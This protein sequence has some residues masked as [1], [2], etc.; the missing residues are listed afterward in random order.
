MWMHFNDRQIESRPACI[1]KKKYAHGQSKVCSMFDYWM[2]EKRLNTISYE[3]RKRNIFRVKTTTTRAEIDDGNG[4]RY[5]FRFQPVICVPLR[6]QSTTTTN[7]IHRNVSNCPAILPKWPAQNT[8]TVE[9]TPNAISP[10]YNSINAVNLLDFLLQLQMKKICAYRMHFGL[11]TIYAQMGA[12]QCEKLEWWKSRD[13]IKI[14][15]TNQKKNKQQQI[16]TR[17]TQKNCFRTMYI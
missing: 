7:N 8:Y 10:G 16:H 15:T 2:T 5:T 12:F 17:R 14:E 11:C 13:M 9:L 3:F 6:G 1:R 4:A